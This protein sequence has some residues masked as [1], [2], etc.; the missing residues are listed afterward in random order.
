MTASK[1]E[2]GCQDEV[3]LCVWGEDG[4]GRD[5]ASSADGGCVL[6]GSK[7]KVGTRLVPRGPLESKQGGE[8]ISMSWQ[9]QPGNYQRRVL[10]WEFQ[11]VCDSRSAG[12]G[13]V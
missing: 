2:W 9:K 1:V 3:S 10:F 8:G 11:K 4:S 6:P 12:L 13:G 5:T 7:P